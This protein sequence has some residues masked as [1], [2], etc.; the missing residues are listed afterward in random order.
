VADALKKLQ[1]RAHIA[2]ALG[3]K[4]D[5]SPTP[6][7]CVVEYAMEENTTGFLK[8]G[9]SASIV[10]VAEKKNTAAVSSEREGLVRC[11]GER[12]GH[13]V[14]EMV[15]ITS[16]VYQ[17]G[18]GW[19]KRVLGANVFLLVGDNLTLVDAGFKGRSRHIIKQVQGLG[20][21][22]SDIDSIIITHH[23]ADHV[24]GLPEM[25]KVSQA[26][27]IAHPADAV[28]IDGHLQ[29]PGPARPRWLSKILA[30]L[31]RLWATTPVTVDILVNDGDDLT[32]FG[33]IRVLHTP[34]HTPGSI[35]LFLQQERLVIV[36]DVIAHRFGL[37]LPSRMFTVDVAQEIRSIK[38]VADLDFDVICFGHGPPIAHKAHSTVAK[39]AE[40]LQ[41][42]HHK[43]A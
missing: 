35:S 8:I 1:E 20:Y 41:K 38:E 9:T 6:S 42:K 5:H 33:G 43:V 37:S 22:P 29:Q 16:R 13:Q 2:V 24:G 11:A 40:T 12:V 4:A 26:K 3:K 14:N 19:G 17:L 34:G 32:M 23:H 30:P 36:G 25:K 15:K 27:V 7:Q 28:Y 31:G 39:F 10:V 21:S 18:S